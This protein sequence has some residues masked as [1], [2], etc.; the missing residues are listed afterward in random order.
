M[1]ALPAGGISVTTIMG[2]GMSGNQFPV[3]HGMVLLIATV[4]RH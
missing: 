4:K 2:V 1:F 3:S